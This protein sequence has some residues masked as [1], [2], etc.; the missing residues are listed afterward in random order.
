MVKF[1]RN[2]AITQTVI[3]PKTFYIQMLPMYIT[4]KVEIE[5]CRKTVVDYCSKFLQ[6]SHD[7]VVVRQCSISLHILDD[8][9]CSFLQHPTS[10][11]V[12]YSSFH[13]G[14]F[15]CSLMIAL[16]TVVQNKWGHL[17]NHG[18][19]GS[20]NCCISHWPK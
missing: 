9:L 8:S 4:D 10:S 2:Y 5:T 11:W 13:P 6:S 14:P 15:V 19:Y 3:F 18:L 1:S 7:I 17:V 16:V 12:R 20:T